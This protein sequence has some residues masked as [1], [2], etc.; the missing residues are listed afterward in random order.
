MGTLV[1]GFDT[2]TFAACEIEN[3]YAAA[4]FDAALLPVP[5]PIVHCVSLE[6][7]PQNPQVY[8]ATTFPS[9]RSLSS[10]QRIEQAI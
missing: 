8:S 3:E 6:G 9:T 5:I 10:A 7:P 4:Q 2:V 1:H